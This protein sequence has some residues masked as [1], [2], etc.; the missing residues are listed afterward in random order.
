MKARAQEQ[1]PLQLNQCVRMQILDKPRTWSERGRITGIRDH[2]KSYIVTPDDGSQDKLCNCRHVKPLEPKTYELVGSNGLRCMIPDL[3]PHAEAPPN[4][5]GDDDRSETAA[6][7]AQMMAIP[8][9]QKLAA[10]VRP[11]TNPE[12]VPATEE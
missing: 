4:N 12:V 5:H 7:S 9:F 2:G 1:K 8:A 3:R 10:I 11:N 6:R